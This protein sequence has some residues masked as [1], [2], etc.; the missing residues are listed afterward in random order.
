M[1]VKENPLVMLLD[2][3]IRL[4]D[5]AQNIL[6]EALGGKVLTRLE[7]LALISITEAGHPL[8]ISQLGRNLGHSRQVMQRAV[9]RLIDLEFLKKLENPD[10]KTAA[11]LEPTAK[12]LKFEKEMGEKLIR[13][14]SGLLSDGDLKTCRNVYRDLRK[15]RAVIEGGSDA[16]L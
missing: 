13:I 16:N 10:H 15:L 1:S 7:R 4:R 2:E 14:V 9:N 8:T 12:G 3:S 5:S 11:L 6:S